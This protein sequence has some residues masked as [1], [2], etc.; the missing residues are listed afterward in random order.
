MNTPKRQPA[1]ILALGLSLAAL[2]AAVAGDDSK[3]VAKKFQKM[4]TNGDGRISSA[5]YTS[6]KAEKKHWWNR[7]SNSA[8]ASAHTAEQFAA[9][10]RDQ[11]GFLS[12]TELAAKIEK[13]DGSLEPT[14]RSGDYSPRDSATPNASAGPDGSVDSGATSS[15]SASGHNRGGN[16][17]ANDASQSDRPSNSDGADRTK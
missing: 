5:E 3:D 15:G 14:G 10:D 16:N 17:S 4:D 1:I 13:K 12:A 7:S 2:P 9:L 8:E 11:D 6:G